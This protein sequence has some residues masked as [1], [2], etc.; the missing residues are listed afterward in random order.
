MKSLLSFIFAISSLI[1]AGSF[2]TA[3][4][5]SDRYLSE[6]K[7]GRDKK[8]LNKDAQS[9]ETKQRQKINQLYDRLYCEY[10][11]V[12]IPKNKFDNAQ[13]AIK[14]NRDWKHYYPAWNELNP[15]LGDTIYIYSYATASGEDFHSFAIFKNK[16]K[17]MIAYAPQAYDENH[18]NQNPSTTLINLSMPQQDQLVEKW[19]L[20]H[21][22][23]IGKKYKTEAP[24]VHGGNKISV[25]AARIFINGLK[26]TIDT[27]SYG[28]LNKS[29]WTYLQL[30]LLN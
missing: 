4:E 25:M 3:N 8:V 29:P 14:P 18:V 13:N 9:N 10:W 11:S 19:D 2:T 20:D 21:F 26:S 5:T 16:N 22:K 15:K 28:Y 23:E 17:V 27:V 24:L 7:K 30:I 6:S 1:L 12:K